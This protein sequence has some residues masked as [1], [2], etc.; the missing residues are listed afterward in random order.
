MSEQ[1]HTT[2]PTPT[3]C[4]FKQH[5]SNDCSSDCAL[6]MKSKHKDDGGFDVACAVAVV[7]HN[8]SVIAA[9]VARLM[10]GMA[11]IYQPPPNTRGSGDEPDRDESGQKKP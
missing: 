6:A 2:Q 7:A 4:P 1:T 11:S 8:S 10:S 9:G 5:G 3:L